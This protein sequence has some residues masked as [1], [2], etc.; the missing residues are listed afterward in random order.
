MPRNKGIVRRKSLKETQYTYSDW[1]RKPPLQ[2]GTCDTITII[3]E[4]EGRGDAIFA[5]PIPVLPYV[6]RVKS[7]VLHPC[8]VET[9]PRNI[10]IALIHSENL[11]EAGALLI[12]AAG[13]AVD[14]DAFPKL[15][16]EHIEGLL[17]ALRSLCGIAFGLP[18]MLIRGISNT[19]RLHLQA[20]K[21]A[22]MRQYL[23]LRMVLECPL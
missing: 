9:K 18:F 17:V 12:E 10:D 6:S 13:F 8:L 7:D 20:R 11:N 1:R 16:P 15:E 2:F 4:R 5:L 19:Q 22:L 3:G 21:L 23:E 14:L